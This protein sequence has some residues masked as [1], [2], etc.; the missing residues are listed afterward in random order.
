MIQIPVFQIM[1][2]S[3]S[4]R[5]P[6]PWNFQSSKSRT[7]EVFGYPLIFS[8][9]WTATSWFRLAKT[10]SGCP[11]SS[12]W[13]YRPELLTLEPWRKLDK[14]D[15]WKSEVN[16]ISI[17][18]SPS[19]H[20]SIFWGIKLIKLIKSTLC[21]LTT[22]TPGKYLRTCINLDKYMRNSSKMFKA[23]FT[24]YSYSSSPWNVW[25]FENHALCQ[26]TAMLVLQWPLGLVEVQDWETS[27]VEVTQGYVRWL[28]GGTLT[29]WLAK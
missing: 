16:L 10:A 3:E 25:R 2:L 19:W 13:G 20:G 17:L 24:H 28:E 6:K 29:L 7:L 8:I 26:P 9:N 27:D 23:C 4:W 12:P 15:P 18:E 21:S 22:G 1:E 11:V 14:L 5:S